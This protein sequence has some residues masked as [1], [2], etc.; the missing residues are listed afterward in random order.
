MQAGDRVVLACAG[1]DEDAAGVGEVAGIA[2]HVPGALPAEQVEATVA[3]VSPHAPT[4]WGRL[5]RVVAASADRREPV[6]P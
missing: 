5:E 6:C 1:L 2:L 3:H 4:A